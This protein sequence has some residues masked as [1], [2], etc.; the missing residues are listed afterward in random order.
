MRFAIA[1]LF[2]ISPALADSDI[3]FQIGSSA[4]KQTVSDADMQRV[5]DHAV[6]AYNNPEMPISSDEAVRR[7]MNDIIT[8]IFGNVVSG[9]KATASKTAI[10]AIEPIKPVDNAAIVSPIEVVPNIK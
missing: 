5:V 7:M 3:L 6:K 1:L 8:S 10:D 2:L 4:V 9:E